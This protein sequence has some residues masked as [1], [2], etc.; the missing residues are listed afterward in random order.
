[1]NLKQMRKFIGAVLVTCSIL[2]LF[3]LTGCKDSYNNNT[4]KSV[5]V[6]NST[7]SYIGSS[8]ETSKDQNVEEFDISKFKPINEYFDNYAF[9]VSI[10]GT[11]EDPL[12]F[13]VNGEYDLNMDGKLDTIN[14][15][16]RSR[17]GI[18][19][20]VQAYLQVNDLKEEINMEYTSDGEV[21][22]IDLD[23]NDKYVEIA[24]FDEGPSGDPAYS[25]YRYDGKKLYN[26]GSLSSDVI[27]DGKGSFI[28]GLF[29]SKFEPKF[30]SASYEI[31]DNMFVRRDN[32]IQKYLG[33]N[34]KFAGGEAYFI[35]AKELPDNFEARW[36]E[37]KNFDASEIKIIDVII[38]PDDRILNYYF[39]EFPNGDKG[40][41]YFWIGD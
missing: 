28:P 31:K 5:E 22:I 19:K 9:N 35:P 27:Y 16:L 24:Y 30:Y 4:Q 20:S 12:S 40:M 3:F 2:L 8:S 17:L 14:L 36:E 41:L 1:M 15:E 25:F 18:E 32:D 21:R 34:Y 6:V 26:I 37:P 29:I 33:K 23:K 39:V 7:D 38:N 10:N 11:K 13:K